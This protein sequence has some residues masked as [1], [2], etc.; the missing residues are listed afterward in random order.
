MNGMSLA[1]CT[2]CQNGFDSAANGPENHEMAFGHPP[3]QH[4]TVIADLS[5]SANQPVTIEIPEPVA[6]L[7]RAGRLTLAIVPDPT[8]PR[9]LGL[10]EITLNPPP[11]ADETQ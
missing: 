2:K 7:I 5:A 8:Q 11:A 6:D 1:T 9:G 4:H 10:R 3:E